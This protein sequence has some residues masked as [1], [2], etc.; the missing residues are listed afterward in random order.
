MQ[1]QSYTVPRSIMEL[2]SISCMQCFLQADLP[3]REQ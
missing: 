2:S 1:F 3:R